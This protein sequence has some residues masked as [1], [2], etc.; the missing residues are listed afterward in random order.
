MSRH[1][2]ALGGGRRATSLLRLTLQVYGTM[3][4]LCGGDGAD[5]R[6]H[7]VPLSKGGTDTLDNSRPA[8]RVCNAKRRDLD[9][10]EWYRLHP[11]PVRPVLTA[12]RQW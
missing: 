6:D 10:T 4:H 3:C 11:L 12:S 7:R 9:L 2:T 8:H 5:T 1:H